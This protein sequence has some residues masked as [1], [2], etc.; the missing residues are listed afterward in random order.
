M[1]IHIHVYMDK[2]LFVFAVGWLGSL[3]NASGGG[4][5]GD[6]FLGW[7]IGWLV[8]WLLWLVGGCFGSLLRV[9]CGCCMNMCIYAYMYVCVCVGACVSR[10]LDDFSCL[11]IF[12]LSPTKN[13]FLS[14][15][16]K[17]PRP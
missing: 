16:Q 5:L 3:F 8:S 6:W 2:S 10:I 7:L 1:G 11:E 14:R 13:C 9:V 17:T 15:P 4:F 12:P